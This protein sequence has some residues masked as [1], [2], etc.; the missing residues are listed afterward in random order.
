MHDDKNERNHYI[1]QVAS[2]SELEKCCEIFGLT[3]I[4]DSN[5]EYDIQEKTESISTSKDEELSTHYIKNPVVNSQNTT[6]LDFYTSYF[7]EPYFD[8]VLVSGE[9]EGDQAELLVVQK[10]R[11]REIIEINDYFDGEDYKVNWVSSTSERFEG[12]SNWDEKLGY[13]VELSS[14]SGKQLFIEIKS[15]WYDEISF[16]FST[17]E[18]KVAKEKGK[19]YR[20][21]FV[22]KRKAES[23]DIHILPIDFIHN[24]EIGGNK[25]FAFV[26]SQ[27]RCKK[28]EKY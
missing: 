5:D 22:G 20:L 3:E 10:L 19:E 11:K 14:K 23:P 16:Y 7:D 21:I 27:Y 25:T 12:N 24:A 9:K 13:D 1:E 18:L 8:D 28:I 6:S 2:L 17:N 26:I 15:Y 4:C